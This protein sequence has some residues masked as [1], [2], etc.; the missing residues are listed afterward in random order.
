MKN[1]L[2]KKIQFLKNGS[3]WIIIILFVGAGVI[4]LAS[5]NGLKHDNISD[6]NNTPN[7]QTLFAWPDPNAKTIIA[8]P[9]DLNQIKAISKFRSCAG[10]DRAG[11][12]FNQELETDRSM[13]HYL[14]P[15]ESVKGTRDQIR[16]YAP[17]D[18][19]IVGTHLEEY[20]SDGTTKTFQEI[21]FHDGGSIEQGQIQE[22]TEA[23]GRKYQGNSY[24]LMSPLDRNAVFSLNHVNPIKDWKVGDEVKAGELIGYASLGDKDNDF[25][26]D[27]TA[28]YY[29]FEQKDQGIEVLDSIFDHMT[30]SVLAEFA[31]YGLTPEN[32]K[33]TKAQRDAEPCGYD[34][35]TKYGSTV[36]EKTANGNDGGP[37]S[38]DCF[39][40]VQQ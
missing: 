37:T 14:E 18:G 13:K 6:K 5:C 35:V 3:F 16:L 31:Q 19:T 32:T 17:F 33:F 26:L 4:G 39:V 11:Y 8:V 23:S 25:D 34:L 36:C 7:K 21:Y 12:N 28:R 9:V 20:N 15:V 1:K 10:H 29:K 2:Q 30:D 24:Q 38:N 40:Q 22:F 27:Y